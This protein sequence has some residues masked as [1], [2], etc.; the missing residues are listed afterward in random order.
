MT[1][2]K[3][4]IVFVTFALLITLG[5]VVVSAAIMAFYHDKELLIASNDAS[6]TAFE[7]Q[8]NTEIEALEKNA[9][10]LALI[11]EIYST[12]APKN[13]RI[14]YPGDIKE[15]P[16]LNGKRYLFFAV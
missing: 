8:I 9:I 14:F 7:G 6:I 16:E 4:K 10:D 12:L 5:L 3:S 2:I 1:S 11:G 13:R 15:L